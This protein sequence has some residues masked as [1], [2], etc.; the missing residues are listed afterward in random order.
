MITVK[1]YGTDKVCD[2]VKCCNCE[3]HMLLPVGAEICPDCHT[4]G[5]LAWVDENK[6][7]V[8]FEYVISQGYKVESC[9]VLVPSDYLTTETLKELGYK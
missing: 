4:E 3:T 1:D 8:S 6:Q 2:F 7:E 5:V 9:K